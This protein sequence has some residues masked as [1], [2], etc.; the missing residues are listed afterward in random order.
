MATHWPSSAQYA[1]FDNAAKQKRNV[2]PEDRPGPFER[3]FSVLEIVAGS[4][5]GLTLTQ[6]SDLANLPKPTVHRLVRV[7]VDSGAL[8]AHGGRHKT[9]HVG[10]RLWR[11]LY[12]GLEPDSVENYA[13]LVCD[14]LSARVDETCYLVRLQNDGVR[15]VA[16]SV[17]ERGHRLHVV[18]GSELPLHAASSA[19]AILA[20]QESELVDR[21][22]RDPLPP[23][24]AYT[25]TTVDAVKAQLALVRRQG[26]AVCDREID[27]HVMAYACPVH[28]GA[29]GVL[30]SIGVTGPCERLRRRPADYWLEVLRAGADRFADMLR[31]AE[32]RQR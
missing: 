2:A 7:L 30:F 28:L 12:L 22:L 10:S 4:R 11:L 15:A 26:Y 18:P 6:I 32:R 3:H 5:N 1:T 24:T 13:R 19:K 29:A 27:D 25:I 17:S 21:L 23:L 8:Q 20:F 14:D 31:G 16:R 9:F